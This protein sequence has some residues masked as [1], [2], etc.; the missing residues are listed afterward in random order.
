[1][2]D[3]E[4]KENNQ[5]DLCTSYAFT[6]AKGPGFPAHL[7][8]LRSRVTDKALDA[9]ARFLGFKSKLMTSDHL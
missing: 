8:E 6:P 9:A 2:K 1:M 5:T 7:P 4:N 3:V